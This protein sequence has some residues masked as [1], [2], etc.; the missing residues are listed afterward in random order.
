MSSVLRSLLE[1]ARAL[2]FFGPGPVDPQLTHAEAFAALV[3][4]PP[5]PF[6]DL[7]TGGGLP[8]L[9]LGSTWN[10]EGVLLDA[11]ARRTDFLAAAVSRLGLE[12]RV[13]VVTA[14]AE[15]AARD[16][17]LRARF[18]LVTARSFG[19]PAVTAECAVGFLVPGGEIAVSEPPAPAAERWPQEG[20]AQLGLTG[21]DHRQDGG[22]TVAVLRL[23]GRVDDR[24][25]RR[26]GIPTKRPLW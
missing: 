12:G 2:G 13:R 16:P 21:P 8:G 10:V 15:E 4:T 6:L 7:G 22:A 5:G 25:P 17:E 9:V 18:A 1:E 26:T 20:L 19:S 23:A 24:W 11:N 14:R 3:G